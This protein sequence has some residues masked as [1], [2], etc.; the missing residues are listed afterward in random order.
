MS[1]LHQRIWLYALLVLACHSPHGLLVTAEKARSCFLP[2]Q[3]SSMEDIWRASDVLKECFPGSFARPKHFLNLL[4]P[5]AASNV[6]FSPKKKTLIG[7]VRGSEYGCLG[8]VQLIDAN[9]R[10]SAL[11]AVDQSVRQNLREKHESVFFIQSLGVR[12]EARRNGVGRSLMRWAELEAVK[13]AP[14]EAA[15]V[16]LWLAVDA[17]QSVALK[18][19]QTCGFQVV[20][21]A[22]AFGNN[23]LLRKQVPIEADGQVDIEE[24]F[25]I[26]LISQ[27][28]RPG[29][30]IGALVRELG[31]Q[32]VVLLVASFGISILLAP[33]GG[34]DLVSL[35]SG[36]FSGFWGAAISGIAAG[37]GSEALRRLL[38]CQLSNNDER[39]M[40]AA[41]DLK[42][43]FVT[44]CRADPSLLEQ[45]AVVARV[46]GW[47][48]SRIG[49]SLQINEVLVLEV[50]VLVVWQ[51]AVA[52]AEEA[53]F[54]GF[55]QSGLASIFQSFGGEWVGDISALLLASMFFGAVHIFW[56]GE[57][58]AA[59][60]DI[61]QYME[62]DNVAVHDSQQKW[63]WFIETGAWGA[64]YGFIFWMSNYQLIAPIAAHASQNTWWNLEDLRGMARSSTADLDEIFQIKES[65]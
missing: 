11:I 1:E 13:C 5:Q 43:D 60:S 28:L 17:D 18:L 57:D 34:R 45:K 52:F 41:L 27:D 4:T 8:C 24:T 42:E 25:H 36:G 61:L 37:L 40:L 63:N 44:E 53:Y 12:Q 2:V 49:T 64:F 26:D 65:Q 59:S 54:R 58:S 47:G 38:F 30:S 21:R 62:E 7:I 23:L 46:L 10:E 16:E 29:P 32:G 22:P 39:G 33:F 6:F 15:E 56:V 51:T 20:T 50:A 14:V 19:H 35:F 55:L 3:A 9:L 31:A 48:K